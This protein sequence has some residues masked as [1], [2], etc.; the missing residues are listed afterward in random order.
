MIPHE[1]VSKDIQAESLS[2][3]CDGIQKNRAIRIVPEDVPP[4]VA[5]R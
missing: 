4:F 2:R 5:P 1:Y 3:L